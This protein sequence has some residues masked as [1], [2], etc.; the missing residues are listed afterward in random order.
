MDF[1]SQL[2]LQQIN[3]G[4]ST[5]IGTWISAKKSYQFASINPANEETIAE[6]LP[7]DEENLE[8]VIQKATAAFLLWREVPAPKRGDIVRQI[9]NKL[10]EKK[11]LLGSLVALEMGKSMQEGYGEVQEMIDI[12]D[13][14][15]GLARTLCGNTMH[16]ERPRHRMY[17]QWHPYGVVGVIT[18]FNFPVA[19]WAWN[20]FIAAVAGDTIVWKPSSKVALCAIAVQH[21]CNEVMADNNLS[22][23]FSLFVTDD[24]LL[25]EKLLDD[26]R[27]PLISFTGSTPVGQKIA[28]RVAKRF[29]RT[30]FRAGG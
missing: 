27:L 15:V 30:I 18:A 2:N 12:A 8:V 23:I 20:A 3:P 28:E 9:A 25:A 17:E 10:R 7:S 24:N 29:G 21:I 26:S 16:S 1:L 11:D 13:F 19:V 22:G 5:D 4:V 6:V 14:A